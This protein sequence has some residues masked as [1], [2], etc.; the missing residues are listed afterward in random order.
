MGDTFPRFKAAAV[1]VAPVYLDREATIAKACRI[2]EEAGDNGARVISFP[3][4]Y[5]PAFPDWF[6]FYP[7]KHRVCA[8]CN[9]ELFKNAVVV[10][11]PATDQIGRAARKAGMC[12][13]LGVNEKDP[14][15]YGTMYNTLVFFGPDGE[16]L[17][18][19]RK[20]VPT[21]TERLV[22]TGGDGSTLRVF[23]TPYGGFSGLI[24]GENTNSLA[25]FTLLASGEVINASA[26]PAFGLKT[27]AGMFD[28]I[29]IRTRA[30]A[31]EGKIFVLSSSGVFTEEMKDALDLDEPLRSEF[32]G[33]GG[34]A[35][36]VNPRGQII[37][38][39]ISG[40]GIVYADLDLEEIVAG[41]FLHDVIGHYN[42][43]DIFHLK[44]DR[45]PRQRLYT[46]DGAP[47]QASEVPR[48]AA[49]DGPENV[50]QRAL[51]D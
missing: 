41:K 6:H 2:I 50:E 23:Q 34:H 46:V 5:I 51:G 32:A 11:S 42:R 31:Y 14:N 38:G 1:Q 22:H 39:P 35:T 26:W 19:R 21:L 17:G 33:D 48:P 36:I 29:D 15:S 16:L 49:G 30:L 9:I 3:E 24:C 8:R 27:D 45:R 18:K 37:A 20:I 44:I 7:A 4:C 12:V 10:P 43:F 28:A 25:K 40:E 47:S 13:A